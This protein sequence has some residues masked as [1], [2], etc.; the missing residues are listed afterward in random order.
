MR[1][2]GRNARPAHAAG[3]LHLVPFDRQHDLVRARIARDDAQ[4]GAEH[5]IEHG[6]EVAGGAAL[7]GG[8]ND[9]FLRQRIAKSFCRRVRA[10]DADEHL[11]IS[12]AEIDE[13]AGIVLRG[14]VADQRLQDG[15][16]KD[17][18]D[19]GTVPGR[20]RIDEAGELV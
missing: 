9:Q 14:R 4:L 16:G 15:A 17:R 6:G 5:V 12:V 8:A 11:D 1:V 13:L 10:R 19:R 3:A 20:H 2:L 18:A 7:V